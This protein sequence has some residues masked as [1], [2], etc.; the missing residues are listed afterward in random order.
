MF[1]DFLRKNRQPLLLSRLSPNPK[2]NCRYLLQLFY[3]LNLPTL[4]KIL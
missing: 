4:P 2:L 1:L 3:L